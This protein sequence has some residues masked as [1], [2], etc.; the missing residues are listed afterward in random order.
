MIS[1]TKSDKMLLALKDYR[2]RYL[3][4]NLSD[5]DES[6]TRIPKF[7]SA[8]KKAKAKVSKAPAEPI[9]ILELSFV[10]KINQYEI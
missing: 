1:S 6:G 5:L 9:Q 4:K 10:D 8:G 2:K 3:N 7:R